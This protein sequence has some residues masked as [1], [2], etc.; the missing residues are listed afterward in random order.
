MLTSLPEAA[1]VCA[2]STGAVP[3][4]EVALETR[5]LSLW[6]GA[7]VALEDVSFAV[8]A[9]KVTAL[10]GSSGSGKSSLLRCLNR[11][12]DEIAGAR[13]GGQVLIGTLD[14]YAKDTL[15]HELRRRVGMVFQR[16]N[17][18]PMSVYDNVAYGLRLLGIKRRGELDARIEAALK[19]A[20]LWDEVSARLDDSALSL[21]LGQQQRLIVAR[22][23]AVEPEVILMDEPASAL[24]PAAMLRFEEL[25]HELAERYTVLLVTHNMQQAARVSDYTAFLH[26]GRLIEFGETDALFTNPRERLTEDY[27]TGRDGG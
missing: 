3:G 1:A 27:I 26:R 16:P 11:L 19:S 18:F 23:I 22:A 17:P 25:L 13:V 9:R 8:P 10:I 2:S 20:A 6:Y 14:A 21:S 15:V 12:N 4:V 24:D 5:A 7:R